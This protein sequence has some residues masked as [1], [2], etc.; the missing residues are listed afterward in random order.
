[1]R[2]LELGSIGLDVCSALA[3]EPVGEVLRVVESL[4]ELFG[5]AQTA[6]LKPFLS[7]LND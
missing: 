3:P 7:S 1:M 6:E 2:C 4:A 5:S